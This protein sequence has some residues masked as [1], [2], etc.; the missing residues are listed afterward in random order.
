MSEISADTDISSSEKEVSRKIVTYKDLLKEEQR[1]TEEFDR[2]K[3]RVA[4]DI[5]LIK[6][7]L[8]PAG[9]ALNFMGRLAS[10]PIKSGLVSKGANLAVDLLSKRYL[11]RGSGL[12]MTLAGSF[13]VKGAAKLWQKNKARK[14]ARAHKIGS[15]GKVHPAAD[16][17]LNQ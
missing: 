11:F 15:N 13:L 10:G 9:Q 7:K 4:E 14:A 6:L 3:A 16:E 2:H 1:L 17:M 5:N 12:L 8:Q